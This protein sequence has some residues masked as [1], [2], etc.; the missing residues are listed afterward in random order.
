MD[1]EIETSLPG[2]KKRTS[3][4]RAGAPARGRRNP[5]VVDGLDDIGL[6]DDADAGQRGRQSGRAF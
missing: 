1:E 4:R 6:P 5:V 2:T 3:D